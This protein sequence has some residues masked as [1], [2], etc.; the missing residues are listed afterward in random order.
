MDET[1][2]MDDIRMIQNLQNDVF[3]FSCGGGSR[4]DE[5]SIPPWQGGGFHPSIEGRYAQM[6]DGV[7]HAK[8]AMEI[9]GPPGNVTF[10]RSEAAVKFGLPVLKWGRIWHGHLSMDTWLHIFPKNMGQ[11]KKIGRNFGRVKFL[12]VGE[13]QIQIG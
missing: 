5:V 12:R 3:F 7:L 4:C 2:L 6:G 10:L 13:W 11:T 1:L 9:A 8:V